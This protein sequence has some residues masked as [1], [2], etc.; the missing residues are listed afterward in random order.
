M[1]EKEIMPIITEGQACEMFSSGKITC[2]NFIMSPRKA[3][4]LDAYKK[5][6]RDADLAVYQA[7]EE[8]HK[9]L[10]S[11]LVEQT[12]REVRL[13]EAEWLEKYSKSWALAWG[14]AL[15][16]DAHIAFLREKASNMQKVHNAP[17]V[18]VTWPNER[19]HA[20]EGCRE[21]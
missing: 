7:R 12:R 8:Y 2:P 21:K 14:M 20:G 1:S 18:K 19:Y 16:M 6:Q 9:K 5:V 3:K 10:I 17:E 15:Q 4:I 11:E 13:D